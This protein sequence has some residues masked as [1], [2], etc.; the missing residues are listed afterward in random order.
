MFML[1]LTPILIIILYC[2]VAF[3]TQPLVYATLHF[4]A[5]FAGACIKKMAEK[6]FSK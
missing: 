1:S 6:Y 2:T 5:H 4:L 3:L